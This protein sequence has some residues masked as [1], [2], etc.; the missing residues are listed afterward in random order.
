M[1]SAVVAISLALAQRDLKRALA[2]STVENMGLIGL[3]I[4]ISWE[5]SARGATTVAALAM[6]GALAHVWNHGLMKGTMFLGAGSVVHATGTRDLER[7]GGLLRAM[8]LTGG[9]LI[10]GA[11]ALSAL[12]PLNGFVSEWLL[13]QSL[14]ERG[15]LGR[16]LSST[17]AVVGIGAMALT[18]GLAT[19]SFTRLVGISL[20]G[21]PR[22]EKAAHAHESDAR[23]T[24]PLALLAAGCVGAAFVP[25]SMLDAITRVASQVLGA[26][27]GPRVASSALSRIAHVDFAL[28]G[29]LAVLAAVAVW[30][31][32]ASPIEKAETWGCGYSGD[33]PRTQYGARSFSELVSEQVL[34]NALK[35]TVARRGPEG[36]FP[37]PGRLSADLPDP[38]TARVYEPTVWWWARRLASFSWLQRGEL[39][40][41]LV[42]VLAAVLLGMT[43]LLVRG[44]VVT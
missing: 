26:E 16:D 27:V 39:S 17:V 31:L 2:Y 33:A 36:L 35:P 23:L 5:A 12:P 42:Y 30:R 37:E 10:V 1:I 25:V 6:A 4:G 18:G 20:L 11:V 34:P 41:Y 7:H 24:G 44:W 40:W 22:S 9:A 19:L 8:P 38:V 15:L 14:F 43:W 29:L 28:W 21:R 13:Y 32:R 3:G